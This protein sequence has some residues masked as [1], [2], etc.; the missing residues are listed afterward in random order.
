MPT[1]SRNTKKACTIGS[2]PSVRKIPSSTQ[3]IPSTEAREVPYPTSSMPLGLLSLGLKLNLTNEIGQRAKEQSGRPLTRT[4][5]TFLLTAKVLASMCRTHPTSRKVILSRDFR[6][7]Y[8]T[9]SYLAG[10]H[11]ARLEDNT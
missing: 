5:I 9:I 11:T 2:L 8:I 10:F 3:A 6:G 1:S 4:S 7:R